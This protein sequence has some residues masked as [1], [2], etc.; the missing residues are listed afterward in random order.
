MKT[1]QSAMAHPAGEAKLTVGGRVRRSRRAEKA[2]ATRA[3][4][5][6]AAIE[7]VGEYGYAGTSVALITQRAQV[8]QGTFYNY[9]Q[10]RQDLLDQ[11]LP[12]I[13]VQLLAH[14]RKRVHQA[15]DSP[16]AREYARITAFFE[17]LEQTPHLFKILHEGE[18]HAP[19]G[20]R[21]H[22]ALQS[23]NYKRA[24]ERERHRGHLKASSPEEIDVMAEILMGARDYLSA[25]YCV[26]NGEIVQPPN[27]VIDAYMRFVVS[28][29][30]VDQ[31]A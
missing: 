6:A 7:I 19:E 13:S 27:H 10:S 29:M 11:L 23:E 8:A 3:R 9:F 15:E 2:E 14:V 18:I 25:R 12:S 26:R 4:L 17:F 31:P 30:F 1:K 16:I 20:F 28:G 24:L 5:F 21:R 22:V